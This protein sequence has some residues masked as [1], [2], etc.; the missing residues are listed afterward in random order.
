MKN[1][2]VEVRKAR[3]EG[4]RF[5]QYDSREH[6]EAAG[7]WQRRPA[8]RCRRST[9]LAR[10]CAPSSCRRSIRGPASLECMRGTRTRKRA[11]PTPAPRDLVIRC[12]MQPPTYSRSRVPFA[13]SLSR[14]AEGAMVRNQVDKRQQNE[15]R[16]RLP[17]SD[18][19]KAQDPAIR[20]ANKR[21]A[22]S[23]AVLARPKHPQAYRFSRLYVCS[24]SCSTNGC[25]T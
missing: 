20:H 10:M 7:R 1:R 8:A 23:K 18:T 12:S 17:Q 25:S 3:V 19:C 24:G 16:Y 2:S 14:L 15:A 11:R 22:R 5:K 4:R 21:A 9:R 13:G 6:R